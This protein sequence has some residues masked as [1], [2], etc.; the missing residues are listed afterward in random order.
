M[1]ARKVVKSVENV[2][3][4]EGQSSSVLDI[5]PLYSFTIFSSCREK[6]KANDLDVREL[7]RRIE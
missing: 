6:V 4:K 5:V 7:K 2:K 3:I 1:F